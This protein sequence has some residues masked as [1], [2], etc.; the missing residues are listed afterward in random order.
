[1]IR[2]SC[3]LLICIVLMLSVMLIGCKR[4]ES[5][6][7][8]GTPSLQNKSINQTPSDGSTEIANPSPK[9]ISSADLDVIYNGL[10]LNNKTPLKD[11][12]SKLHIPIGETNKNIRIRAAG[13][14]NGMSFDW[15]QVSYP[16]KENEELRFDYLYN[17]TL[18]SG[19]IVSINLINVPTKR[20]IIVGDTIEKIKFAYGKDVA[21]EPQTQTISDI[22]FMVDNYELRFT[23]LKKTGKISGIYIDFDTNKAMEESD[24]PNLEDCA[25]S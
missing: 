11:L 6:A 2:K 13:E 21:E 3:V 5:N 17:E 25:C 10:T 20:G 16:D 8:G 9:V 19:R 22:S 15:Y 23:I 7:I 4:A 12:T 18:K 24:I 14:V 1:M